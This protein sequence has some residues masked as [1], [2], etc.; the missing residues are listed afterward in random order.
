MPKFSGEGVFDARDHLLEFWSICTEMK[1]NEL[2]DVM[3][4]LFVLTLEGSASKWYRGLPNNSI[5][6]YDELER[7]FLEEWD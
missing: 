2:E 1:V 3:M 5:F 4:R 7:K 6:G